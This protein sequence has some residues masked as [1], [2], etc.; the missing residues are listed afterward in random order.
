MRVDV[1]LA[2][3]GVGVGPLRLTFPFDFS[4]FR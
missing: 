3:T 2:R 4:I 1:A